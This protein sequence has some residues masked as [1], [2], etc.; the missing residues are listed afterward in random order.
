VPDFA[1]AGDLPDL[2]SSILAG[3]AAIDWPGGETA[4]AL[5][6]RVRAAWADLIATGR[7]AVVVTHAGPLL[8]AIALAS[9]VVPDLGSIP[10]PA[11][12]VRFRIPVAGSLADPC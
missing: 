2:A 11:T 5:E 1:R 12:E 8:H 10:S 9:D 6:A 4:A 3:S 7:D